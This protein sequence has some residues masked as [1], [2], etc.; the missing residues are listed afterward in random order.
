MPLVV[1]LQRGQLDIAREETG[2]LTDADGFESA[3][4]LSLFSDAR[5]GEDEARG[6]DHRGWWGDTWPEVKGD[7]LGSRLWAVLRG[8]SPEELAAARTAAEEALRWLVTDGIAAAVSCVVSLIDE[9][10]VLRVEISRPK[11]L[12][13]WARAWEVSGHGV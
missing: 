1:R 11:G 4:L 7:K 3:V 10:A 6:D 5:A 12:T 13:R 8:G 9:R 2:A